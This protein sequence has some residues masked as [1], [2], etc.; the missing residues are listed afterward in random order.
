M[1]VVRCQLSQRALAGELWA[2]T[3]S[4]LLALHA[5]GRGWHDIAGALTYKREPITCFPAAMQ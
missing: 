1:L 3:Y 5:A 2:S 4:G